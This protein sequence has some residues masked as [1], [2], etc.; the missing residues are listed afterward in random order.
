MS[1]LTQGNFKGEYHRPGRTYPKRPRFRIKKV[2]GGFVW[3]SR[4]KKKAITKPT[5]TRSEARKKAKEKL[6]AIKLSKRNKRKTRLTME[7][8][9]V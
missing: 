8:G 6:K 3:W 7:A 5:A 2:E 1:I 4:K 9:S